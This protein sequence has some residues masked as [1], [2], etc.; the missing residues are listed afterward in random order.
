[1]NLHTP[2]SFPVIVS[3]LLLIASTGHLPA[4]DIV[5]TPWKK[6]VVHSGEHC[7]TAVAADFTG[8]GQADII[9]NSGGK[10]HLFVAPDWTEVVIDDDPRHGCIHSE[11]MDVDRDGDPDFIG[12][13]YNPGLLYWLECPGAAGAAKPWAYHRI[14]NRIHGIHGVL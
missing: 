11:V 14:H 10:T 6:T 4:A 3:G 2:R 7:M 9:S 8:D 12:A 13:W 1:M 5:E